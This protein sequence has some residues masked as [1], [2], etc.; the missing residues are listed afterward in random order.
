MHKDQVR[1][2]VEVA[3]LLIADEFPEF[4][5]ETVERVDSLGTVNAIFRVGSR[6]TARFPLQAADPA[7]T[8]NGLRRESDAASDFAVSC[9]FATP[10]PLGLGRPGHSYPM[11]WMMQTW[12]EGD[13]AT[14]TGLA[15]SEAFAGDIASL[16]NSMRA[17]DTRGRTFTGEGRGGRIADHDEWMQACFARSSNLLDVPVFSSM[18][19]E[20]RDLPPDGVAVM[21]HKDLIPANILVQG[22]RIVG[23]LDA[24][25]FGPADPA[26]DLVA[27][28]HLLDAD[29]RD[30]VRSHLHVSSDEWLR[31]AAWAFVQAMG[32]VWYYEQ[33]NPTMSALGRSTLQRLMDD[34]EVPR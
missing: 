4:R 5:S 12:L 19:R 11:P 30:L 21:C 13:I 27:V 2:D 22:D 8:E 28:W 24:G 6:A 26:L 14:P 20:L 3:S 17:A 9:P 32:L 1:I 16:L 33:S 15:D 34:P 31:G 18:W 25:G 7:A 23:I 10:R 29:G